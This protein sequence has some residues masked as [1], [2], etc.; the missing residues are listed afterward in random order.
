MKKGVSW[1]QSG[2]FTRDVC[3]G[4]PA[5]VLADLWALHIRFAEEAHRASD[6]RLGK[7][8]GGVLFSSTL[9]NKQAI[10]SN[11]GAVF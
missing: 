2:E 6:A 10:L 11:P 5:H 9:L 1:S 3:S 8:L 7:K 4:H